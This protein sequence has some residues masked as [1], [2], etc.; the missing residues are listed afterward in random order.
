MVADT[1]LNP[2]PEVDPLTAVE[3]VTRAEE[4]T[5]MVEG[6]VVPSIAVA[7]SP[8]KEAEEDPDRQETRTSHQEEMTEARVL[9]TT[10]TKTMK[11]ESLTANQT[12]EVE[13]ETT[14]AADP[15]PDQD[16]PATETDQIATEEEEVRETNPPWTK[17]TSIQK[18]RESQPTPRMAA[19]KTSPGSQWSTVTTT[20]LRRTITLKRMAVMSEKTNIF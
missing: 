19:R 7:N 9:I 15:C 4:E 13:E 8:T 2:D 6:E 10:A 16:A 1:G 11:R 3:T 14:E 5:E 12:R 18:L 17:R 20:L